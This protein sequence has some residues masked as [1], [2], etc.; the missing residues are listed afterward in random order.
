MGICRELNKINTIFSFFFRLCR[1]KSSRSRV[2]MF[3]DIIIIVVVVVV[4]LW[5]ELNLIEKWNKSAWNIPKIFFCAKFYR[6][7]IKTFK[8]DWLIFISRTNLQWLNRSSLHTFHLLLNTN[9]WIYIGY[10]SIY[11][12]GIFL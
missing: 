9:Y 6:N 3:M 4:I 5:I 1:E 8:E 12:C 7:W 10:G 2:S 11:I